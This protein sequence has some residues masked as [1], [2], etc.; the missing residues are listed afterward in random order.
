MGT[1]CTKSHFREP[2]TA[3]PLEYE[4][5]LRPTISE[6]DNMSPIEIF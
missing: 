1:I 3:G 5:T 4:A 2:D 6:S